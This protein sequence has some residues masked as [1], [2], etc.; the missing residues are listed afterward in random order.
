MSLVD[1]DSDLPIGVIADG[2][3]FDVSD[4]GLDQFSV[5]AF[6]PD[7]TESVRFG[8]SG[9]VSVQRTENVASYA[10][11]ANSGSDFRGR[12]ALPGTYTLTVRAFDEN[13]ATGNLL[14]E[15]TLTFTLTE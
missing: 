13:R 3:S 7:G 4:L 11:F 2:D 5:E 10:L 6:A 1:A 8:L 9:P 12:D 15:T 14:A